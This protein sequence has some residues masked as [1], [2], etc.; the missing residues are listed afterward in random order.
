MTNATG[1]ISRARMSDV[2]QAA[3]VSLVTVSRAVN[4]PDKLA[5][6]TL[7]VVRAAIERLGYV[8]NLTAGSLASS[9]SRIVAAV[10]PTISNP[11]F[12][13]TIEALTQTL[14]ESGHQL[15]L[16]QSAYRG[17]EEAALVDA[18]LGRR[19]DGLVLT[20]CNQSP[21]LIVRL[22][23][24]GLPVV[25]TWD[26]PDNGAALVD[27]VVGFSN[28]DAGRLAARHLIE[29]G[30]RSLGFIGA[31]EDRSRRRLDGFKAEAAKLG[32]RT[33]AA[34][35]IRPPAQMDQ[36]GAR[37]QQLVARQP[38]L[39]GVFCNND[40]LAAAVLFECHRVRCPVPRKL[41]VLGFGDQPVARAATPQLS[42]IRIRRAEMGERAGQMLLTRLAGEAPEAQCIDLGFE[43]VA[44]D[45]T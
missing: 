27:M 28:R 43:I 10:V 36:A 16:G 23:R 32:V 14:A 13:E 4:A 8:P 22:K 7:A 9:R 6:E 45:S 5:P 42:T 25:Q 2:A 37:L 38:D 17:A 20:G 30:C 11:V 18:F 39:D 33:V 34:E 21:A 35:L 29:R 44:R 3:G 24:A 31:E 41:A 40:L 1:S 12:S 19:V 15:L 26:L